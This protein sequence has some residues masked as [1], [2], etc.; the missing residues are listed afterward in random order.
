M[1]LETDPISLVPDAA[2]HIVDGAGNKTLG[3]KGD[4]YFFPAG[5]MVIFSTS[6]HGLAYYTVQRAKK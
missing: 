1:A 5:S 2:A 4:V 6:D 3:S